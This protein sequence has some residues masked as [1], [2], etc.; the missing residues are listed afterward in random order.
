MSGATRTAVE[1]D[2]PVGPR[3]GADDTAPAGT[4]PSLRDP[5]DGTGLTVVDEGA[6]LKLVMPAAVATPVDA[7]AGKV[8]GSPAP[9]DAGVC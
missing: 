2:A 6:R 4:T 7:D 3:G 1:V 8:A 5:R 9:S